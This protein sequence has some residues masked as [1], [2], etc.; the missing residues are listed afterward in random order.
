MKKKGIWVLVSVLVVLGLLMAPNPATAQLIKLKYHEAFAPASYNLPVR[1]WMD[2]VEKRTKGE[3]K[4]DRMFGGVL[5]KISE[6]PMAIKAGSFDLGQVSVV[7]NPGL[8]PIKSLT[9]LP[10]LTDN[11]LAHAKAAH[12]FFQSPAVE[13]R[14]TELNQ[15]YLMNGVWITIEM[16]SHVPVRTIDDMRKIKIRAHGG[17]GDALKAIGITTYAVP[18]GELPAA[19]ERRVVD[20]SSMGCPVD[21]FDFGFGDI[22][23]NWQ[24]IKFFYMPYTLVINLD[25]WKKLPVH[26]QQVMKDVNNIMPTK[27][28]E[29][30]REKELEAE[31][32]IIAGGRMKIVEFGEL[33][34]LKAEGGRPVWDKW[35]A[36]RKAEGIDGRALLD[37]F[38]RLVKK[39]E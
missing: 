26:V 20:A 28:Y 29:I 22:F 23:S 34:R 30:Y 19:A 37:E 13:T 9:I 11:V 8:Y 35:V 6:Q 7:Y 4:F 21:A 39:Y 18:W 12:D 15:K 17:A 10:F 1:W 5:G 3:V 25:T 33:A 14:F 38:L 31:K 24:R 2:E 36:D 32:K 16:M 27:A